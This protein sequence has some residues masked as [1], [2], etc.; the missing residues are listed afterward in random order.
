MA[1]E[2]VCVL[3]R[4]SISE[5]VSWPGVSRGYRP[6]L[7]AVRFLAFLLVFIHH[8]LP[9]DPG[10]ATIGDAFSSPG[11]GFGRYLLAAFANSCGMGLCLFF[12]LSAY[13]ITDL[14][15]S[16]REAKGAVSVKRFYL[17]RVL[18]IWPLYVF[19]IVIGVTIAWA[20]CSRQELIM[21]AGYLLFAGNVYAARF[22]ANFGW[23]TNPMTPLWSISIEEQFYLVWPWAMRFLSRRGLGLC[24]LLFVAAAN[25]TLFLL[26]QNHADTDTGVWASTFVQFE[27]FA[28]GIL[29]ALIVRQTGKSNP[30]AGC[31]LVLSGPILWLLACATFHIKQAGPFRLAANGPTL[32]AGYALVALGCAAVLR[33]AMMIGSLHTPHWMAALGKISYGLYVYHL[34]AGLV[35]IHILHDAQIA[36][37]PLLGRIPRLERVATIL[38]QFL[39][40]VLAAK[41]SYK[42]LESP[43]LRLKRRF[44]LVHARP[45]D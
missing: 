24:A 1:S 18:R 41:L 20:H 43:F 8:A 7:D 45:V 10:A 25:L 23:S 22:A 30:V 14:L 9:R 33:G 34:L 27:M 12:A 28:V 42:W 29:L 40:T 4:P 44:E 11:H 39:L 26:G 36:S 3:E 31:G 16:E 15:L 17:R 6:E 2:T 32:M 38:L 19:G 35:A 37:I 21:L 13:L 5:S